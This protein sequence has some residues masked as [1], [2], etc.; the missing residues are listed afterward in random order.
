MA[1]SASFPIP[2]GFLEVLPD[3]TVLMNLAGEM[4]YA[5]QA[6]Q[7][8]FGWDKATIH[9]HSLKAIL[10]PEESQKLQAAITG[11]TAQEKVT[12]A[13]SLPEGSYPQVLDV[14]IIAHPVENPFYFLLTFQSQNANSQVKAQKRNSVF[15]AL[16][17]SEETQKA[18]LHH[19]AFLKHSIDGLFAFDME[20]R[21]TLWN[22]YMEG[23][24]GKPKEQ[25]VGRKVA[26]VFPYFE[27]TQEYTYFKEALT[28]EYFK[29]TG[30]QAHHDRD[31]FHDGYLF[32]IKDSAQEIIGAMCILHEVTQQIKAEQEAQAKG[33]LLQEAQT[34]AQ[35][36]LSNSP[37]GIFT[38]TGPELVITSWNPTIEKLSG[39]AAKDI[40]GKSAFEF[41]PD[42]RSSPI[43]AQLS[44]VFLG[45]T[46]QMLNHVSK[47]G[48]RVLNV[49][50][51]P[52][53]TTDG[54]V[55]GGVGHIQ[56]VTAQFN[57]EKKNAMA[58]QEK[59][60]AI[61]R[62]VLQTQ[63]EEKKRMAELLHNNL[64]Q[65]LYGTGM[66]LK[67][68]LAT[69]KLSKKHQEFL[70]RIEALVSEAIS[71]T[72]K[73]SF[74]LMPSLLDDFGLAVALEELASKIAPASLQVQIKMELGEKRPIARLEICLYRIVQEL[75]NN[76]IKHAQASHLFVLIKR[77]GKLLEVS[78][79]DNGVG[80]AHP[81]KSKNRGAGLV[82]IQNRVN[83]QGGTWT[84][85]SE[86]GKGTYNQILLPVKG[87]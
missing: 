1:L 63:E 74:E 77:T 9:E 75:M 79:K 70:Q 36:I 56:N 19:S 72:K 21:Y 24:T 37:V 27:K 52:L 4:L 17:Q 62:A 80:Y 60:L 10:S 31:K 49:Y 55:K 12:I 8:T 67:Q 59:Q 6:A 25:V 22:P 30:R 35:T 86:P 84:V 51:K 65:T 76:A 34:M 18:L 87:R 7:H 57:L 40:I 38:F 54:T 42:Y 45:E 73:I 44:R 48:K 58:A 82:N 26:D 2:A 71:D 83:A 13:I 85:Q 3:P 68:Y 11:Q 66:Q 14:Q 46:L 5:N 28:G 81:P 39:I 15:P 32:P 47:D 43:V 50:F 29:V 78:V 64:G 23:L 41:Y 53:I 33:Q 16:M 69:Q 61:M 20:L